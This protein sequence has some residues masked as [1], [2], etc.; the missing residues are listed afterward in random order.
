M[1][2]LLW[3]HGIT[4]HTPIRDIGW[5]YLVMLGLGGWATAVVRRAFRG[6]K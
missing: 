3:F 6:D 2:D 1:D 4:W 5:T